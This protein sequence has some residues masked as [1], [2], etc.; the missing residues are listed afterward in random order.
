MKQHALVF[1]HGMGASI[2]RPTT[3]AFGTASASLLQ[4]GARQRRRFRCSFVGST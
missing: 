1:V 2:R 4:R 3:R